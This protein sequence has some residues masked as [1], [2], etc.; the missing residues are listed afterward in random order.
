MSKKKKK[1]TEK[2]PFRWQI[3]LI[4][5]LVLTVI[6]TAITYSL[7]TTME[8]M[9][10]PDPTDYFYVEDYS[11]VLNEKTE[12]FIMDEAVRLNEATKAQVVVVTVPTTYNDPLYSYSR[13]IANSW[14]IGDEELDNGVLLLFV[15]DP[16]DPHIRMEVGQGLEGALPDGKAGRILDDYA[17]GPRDA[18]Q[19]NK[20]AGDSFVAVLQE[21][22]GEY[23]VSV[24]ET[25]DFLEWE[26]PDSPTEGTFADADLPEPIITENDAPFI[27]QL[28]TAFLITLMFMAFFGV[29]TVVAIVVTF[30]GS[31]R[32]R[33]SHFGGGST[34]GGGGSSFSGG[35]GS[36]GG[37]GASR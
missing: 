14:G 22:Y 7:N 9:V 21:V 8:E 29:I 20:A 27:D 16:N 24:P 3:I 10:Y 34:F 19:W 12:S 28:I 33:R 11:H 32:E 2:K 6:G 31:S 30:F 25:V 4:V 5:F 36:F 18:G 23:G 13:Q 17:V 26:D 1:K 15:T 37:G 35:G